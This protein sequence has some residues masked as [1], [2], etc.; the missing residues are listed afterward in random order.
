M[1]KQGTYVKK[2]DADAFAEAIL[3]LSD[4]SKREAMKNDCIKTAEKFDITA[5]IEQ[6]KKIYQEILT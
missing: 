2:N 3:L 6:R 5:S 4:S 1:I